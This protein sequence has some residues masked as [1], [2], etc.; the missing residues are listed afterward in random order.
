M[1]ISLNNIKHVYHHILQ[2][3]LEFDGKGCTI[4]ILVSNDTDSLA[5]LKILSV[6]K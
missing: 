1:L 6:S 2:N 5:A 4:Y 3:A